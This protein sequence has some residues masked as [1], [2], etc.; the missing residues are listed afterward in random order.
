[1]KIDEKTRAPKRPTLLG[2]FLRTCRKQA[3]RGNA[4]SIVRAATSLGYD[5]NSIHAYETGARLPDVQ[6]LAHAA[7]LY[8]KDFRTMLGLLLRDQQVRGSNPPVP[9]PVCAAAADRI[10]VLEHEE[11]LEPDN[12][13]ADA[14]NYELLT[15]ILQSVE[16]SVIKTGN[17]LQP[18]YKARIVSALYG[19]ALAKGPDHD[20]GIEYLIRV[21]Q[22]KYKKYL[23]IER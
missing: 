11:V 22:G 17:C 6:F 8:K 21:I 15:G 4:M 23:E 14:L 1:M 9:D 18:K 20:L 19:V 5:K 16:R 3:L 10:E 2:N 12:Q 7:V 13:Y